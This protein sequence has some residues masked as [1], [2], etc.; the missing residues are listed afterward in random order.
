MLAETLNYTKAAESL[1]LTP[2]A[3]SRHIAALEGHLGVKL[4]NRTT[5]S[6]AL[7][8]AGRATY[9]A[10]CSMQRSYAELRNA[11]AALD[12]GAAQAFTLFA[13]G[14]WMRKYIEPVALS[15][16]WRSTSW[17][18]LLEVHQ[19][20]ESLE[21]LRLGECDLFF[22]S[23]MPYKLDETIEMR[24]YGD[25]PMAVYFS[26]HDSFS[27]DEVSELKDFAGKS[28]VLLSDGA[29]GYD[30][31]NQSNIDLFKSRG[32]PM[33]EPIYVSQIE[34]AGTAIVQH[35]A[36][37]CAPAALRGTFPET[38]ASLVLERD[39]CVTPLCFYYRRNDLNP[40]IAAF[41]EA[42]EQLRHRPG[43]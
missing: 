32:I 14:Y 19:P 29:N 31:V 1:F 41:I 37:C 9:R 26:A 4:L 39:R 17:K 10:F 36:V 2:P 34:T 35:Q 28:L 23:G 42:A 43:E 33:A 3:L 11:I 21:S 22:G 18:A 16:A 40:A 24:R 15:E 13:P 20:T 7:T 27:V 6:V 5:R 30:A 8:E 12:E 38:V 25:E